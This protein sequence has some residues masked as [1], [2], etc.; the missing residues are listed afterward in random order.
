MPFEVKK[1]KQPADT[2]KKSSGKCAYN[3]QN[4]M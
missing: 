1:K 3:S 4:V 2:I